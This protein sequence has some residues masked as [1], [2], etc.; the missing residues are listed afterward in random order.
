MTFQLSPVD[1][2]NTAEFSE[3]IAVQTGAHEAPRQ[4]IYFLY[5]PIRNGNR[6]A[7]IQ[8][9]SARF[10]KKAREDPHE[11]WFKVVDT[12]TGRIAGAALWKI[13]D[14]SPFAHEDEEDVDWWPENSTAAEFTGQMLEQLDAPR[15]EMGSV[16]QVC[17]CGSDFDVPVR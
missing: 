14:E 2:D 12:T 10:L 7:H 13:H 16:P 8:E 9:T 15:K 11:R 4:P 17:M 6:D 3:L 1:L 5:C